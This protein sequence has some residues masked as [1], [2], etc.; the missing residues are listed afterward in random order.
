MSTTWGAPG[1]GAYQPPPA[2]PDP[3]A[4]R[5]PWPL[6]P[7]TVP[8]AL[9]VGTVVAGVLG[10]LVVSEL[11]WSETFDVPGT[12]TFGLVFGGSLAGTLVV[13]SMLSTARPSLVKAFAGLVGTTVAV[14]LVA[15]LAGALT[16]DFG[17]E[18]VTG[19]RTFLT[20]EPADAVLLPYN[21]MLATFADIDTLTAEVFDVRLSFTVLIAVGILMGVLGVGST[22]ASGGRPASAVLGGAGAAIGAVAGELFVQVGFSKWPDAFFNGSGSG[23]TP[24]VL[25]T[26]VLAG[27]GLGLGALLGRPHG[28]P[29]A[30]A[31]LPTT[32]GAYAPPLATPP[33]G[34]AAP[35][36]G[37]PAPVPGHTPPP[38]APQPGYAPPGY[39]PP[40]GPPPGG[41]AF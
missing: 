16:D 12:F 25:S 40:A 14:A 2:G 41:T 29:G 18:P 34:Y 9:I 31:P 35:T 27:V 8:V 19:N 37:A 38:T 17:F 23:P 15:T 24:L 32:P 3:R 4:G 33:P 11:P 1:Q 10:N 7:L 22:L 13:L 30:V 21:S 36:G 26:M 5:G 39:T 28:R 6:A 20:E